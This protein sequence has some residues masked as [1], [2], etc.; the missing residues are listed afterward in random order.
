MN[1]TKLLEERKTENIGFIH[2]LSEKLG[3]YSFFDRE[4]F[5]G[6]N[7]NEKIFC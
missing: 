5:S 4:D 7:L 3:V 1:L 2:L 6:A